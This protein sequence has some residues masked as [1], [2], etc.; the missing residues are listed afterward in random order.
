MSAPFPERDRIPTRTIWA[1][2]LPHVAFGAVGLPFMLYLMKFS[3]DVLLIAPVT[4]GTLFFASRLWDAV[5]DPMTGFLSDRTRSKLGRRRAWMFAA[6]VPIAIG[7][8]MLWSPPHGLGAVEMIVWMAVALFVYETASTAWHIPHG[9]LGVEL[10]PNYHER[11]RIFG[12]GHLIR[13]I[14]MMGGVGAFWLLENADDARALAPPLIFGLA[15]FLVATLLTC[16]W[17]VPERPEFQG[18]GSDHP[19]RSLIDVA[20]NPHARLLL[21]VYAV[22]T[23]GVSSLMLLLPYMTEY[24]LD[25]PGRTT[26]IIV[27]YIVPQFAFTPLWIRLGRSTEKKKMWLA[28]MVVMAV[29][30]LGFF[31]IEDGTSPLIYIVPPILG[32]AGGC[33]AVVAPS[34]KADII[35]YDEYLTGERKEGTYL[36]VWNLV[37]KAATALPALFTGVVLQLADFQPNQEQSEETRLAMRAIFG[38]APAVCYAIGA[39]IFARFSFNEREHGKVRSILEARRADLNDGV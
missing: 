31:F 6:P 1:Y 2:S 15:V 3:T 36:A 17:A 14:G 5:S 19:F 37:R 7:T 20:R 30:F 27:L 39:L 16:T 28:A 23:F 21:F 33:G 8:V 24:V 25:L 34:I 11:T 12:Y 22:E 18:R 13:A 32:A 4:M 9:A 38:I 10:S 35:D 26:V 29:G